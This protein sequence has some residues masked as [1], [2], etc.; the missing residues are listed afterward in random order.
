MT[1]TV[2]DELG[3]MIKTAESMLLKQRMMRMRTKKQMKRR[4][5]SM[6]EGKCAQL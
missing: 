5:M 2:L 6:G 3:I 4:K 1:L